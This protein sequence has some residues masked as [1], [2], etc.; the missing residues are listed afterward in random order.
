MS[1]RDEKLS[2]ILLKAPWWVSVVLSLVAF[3]GLRWF[4]PA[5]IGESG[6]RA[7]IGKGVSQFAPWPA[8]ILLIL[9][10]GSFILSRRKREL[11]DSQTDLESLRNVSWKHFE[12]MVGEAYRRL[13]FSVEDSLG[14]GA[15]GGIDL[16]LRKDGE[17]TIVQCKQWKVLSVGA[18]VVRELYGLLTH[19]GAAQAIIVTS[20]RFSGE[21]RSFAAGKPIELVDGPALLQLVRSVQTTEMP[22]PKVAINASPSCP[23]CG[24]KMVQRTAKRGPNAGNAFWG[25]A[26]YP[27]CTG[28]REITVNR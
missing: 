10:A 26:S 11:V 1:R 12:W 8:L 9:A 25:C 23:K 2:D 5:L 14:S 7:A 27:A 17:T 16:T 20:G 18:P 19:H 3:T 4:A 22:V 24:A 13:G 28:T 15:D 6:N 21:A